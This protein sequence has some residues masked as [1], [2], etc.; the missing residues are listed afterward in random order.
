MK[1][2]P[3][4]AR[5][6][7]NSIET[8]SRVTLTG[9]QRML[10]ALRHAE[11]GGPG[12]VPLD[13][14]PGLRDLDRLAELASGA[15]VRVEV[16][17]RGERRA[18]PP[19]TDLSVFRIIQEAVTNVVR[20]SGAHAC[21]VELAFEAGELSIEVVDGGPGHG[22]RSG[23]VGPPGGHGDGGGGLGLLGM[24]ERV[25]MLSGQFS[26]GPLPAGGFRVAAR[27]PA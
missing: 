4:A 20:H 17:W 7:L 18:L 13:P 15:G 27:I 11:S 14:L 22:D 21:Q 23:R 25:S 19:E 24:R 6:A 26:A 9:L 2:Q 3:E 16:A 1:T 12:A 5:E 8:T 10:R